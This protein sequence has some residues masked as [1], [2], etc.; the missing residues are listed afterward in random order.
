MHPTASIDLQWLG[1]PRSI[2]TAL[3]RDNHVAALIDPG[4]GST[5]PALRQELANLGLRVSD[6]SSILRTHI[7]LD[8]AGATGALVRENPALQ[9]YVHQRGVPHMIDPK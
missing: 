9:V 7:H 4:P 8:H 2:A 6:L 1:H 5:L 3:L